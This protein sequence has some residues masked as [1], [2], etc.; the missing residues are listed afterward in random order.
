[1]ATQKPHIEAHAF[2]RFCKKFELGEFP[3]QRMGQA[4]YNQFGLHKMADQGYLG[5]LYE[6]DGNEAFE[7]IRTLFDLH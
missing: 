7:K 1:M 5:D 6:L 2:T 4:F 3:S